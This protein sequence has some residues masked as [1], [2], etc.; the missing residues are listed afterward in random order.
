MKKKKRFRSLSTRLTRYIMLALLVVMGGMS[1]LIYVTVE[2]ILELNNT[3]QHSKIVTNTK[4]EVEQVLD[5]VFIATINS[6]KQIQANLNHPARLTEIMR[7][8]VDINHH[9]RSCGISFT[10]NYYPQHG[11]LFCPYAVRRDSTHI[12]VS[13]HGSSNAD[14]LGEQWFTDALQSD[15][16][17]WSEPYRAADDTTTLL[18]ACMLPIRNNS[19]EKVA[20][21]GVDLSLRWL[22]EL[23]AENDS[24][25][26]N[27]ELLDGGLSEDPEDD[28]FNFIVDSTGNYIAFPESHARMGD[29]LAEWAESTPDS[30]DDREV[31]RILSRQSNLD[32]VKASEQL[33]HVG[34]QEC[35]LFYEPIK[36]MG[37][38]VV[39]VVP[40]IYFKIWAYVFVIFL[41][42]FIFLAIVIVFVVGRFSIRR[43]IK[44]LQKLAAATNEVA[45]GR[46]DTPLPNIRHNDEVKRL[47]D[48]FDTMQRSLTS[49]VS[50]LQQ[51]TAVKAAMESELNVAH[52]IQMS[53]LPKT[54]PPYPDRK[55]IDIY[56][57]LKPAKAVGGDLFDFFLHG[58]NLFF[59]VGDV[60]GKGVPASLVMAVT[61]ALLRNVSNTETDPN[62]IVSKVNQMIAADNESNMFVTLFVGVL[63]LDT[64]DLFYCNA[65]HD[66]PLI[67]GPDVALLPCDPNLPVGILPAF[68]FTLQRTTMKP[69]TTIFVFTD[70][71]NEAEDTLHNQFGLQRIMAVAEHQLSLRQHSPLPLID[72]MTEQMAAFVRDAEQSDDLT[73]LAIEYRPNG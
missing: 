49:Y 50:E 11:R 3:Q 27:D 45:Q 57:R 29:N 13:K 24:I 43:A 71:L 21:L 44:P 30:I 53:M 69:R 58:D 36:Q 16:C 1:W 22:Q 28:I 23:L 47:R 35:F 2:A 32:E 20:V 54:F 41:V 72:A 25:I 52:N 5:D 37:W 38:S 60:S 6:E 40:K 48:S 55:D 9:I 19:G 66:A 26:N 8:M 15:S 31:K 65:G 63:H 56:G 7:D 67:I 34:G 33:V 46:F 4:A 61:R 73:M 42:I 51:T 14:Y 10:E 59:A 64:G 39:M 12:D 68:D 70:G 62:V 17:S 18:I